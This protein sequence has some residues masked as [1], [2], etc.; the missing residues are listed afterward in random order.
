MTVFWNAV[1][2]EIHLQPDGSTLISLPIVG[3]VHARA[4]HSTQWPNGSQTLN[5][6]L[7][8]AV[9]QTTKTCTEHCRALVQA[10]RVWQAGIEQ[11]LLAARENSKVF[12]PFINF[13][14]LP[15]VWTSLCRWRQKQHELNAK[16]IKKQR[17][18]KLSLKTSRQLWI[19]LQILCPSFHQ[20]VCHHSL[21]R[22]WAPALLSKASPLRRRL[23]QRLPWCPHLAPTI[24]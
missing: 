18:Y 24:S 4:G 23:P 13:L 11:G 7:F 10:F 1:S 2:S 8:Q 20:L 3:F 21:G 5:G 16:H 22:L 12:N 14:A 17:K 6:C 19:L 15:S 9:W